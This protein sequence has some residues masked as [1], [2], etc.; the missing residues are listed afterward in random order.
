MTDKK[1]PRRSGPPIPNV[2][3]IRDMLQK[4]SKKK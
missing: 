3:Q 2:Q 1:K 4:E